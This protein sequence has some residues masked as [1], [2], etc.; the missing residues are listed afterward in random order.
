[1]GL[2]KCI[3]SQKI[4]LCF[5]KVYKTIICTLHIVSGPK[6]D[7]NKA[8]FLISLSIFHLK[9]SQAECTQTK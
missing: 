9:T 7:L 4:S 2:K 8:L 1:M 3:R 6:T 5:G